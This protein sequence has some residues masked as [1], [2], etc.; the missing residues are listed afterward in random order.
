MFFFR[1]FDLVVGDA[2][3]DARRSG[4]GQVTCDEFGIEE[5]PED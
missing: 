1:V 2:V 4:V 5:V 3:E